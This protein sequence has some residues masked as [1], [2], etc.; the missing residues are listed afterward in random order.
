VVATD[1]SAEALAVAQHNARRHAL[2]NVTFRQG[3]WWEPLQ[4]QQFDLVVS[5]PPYIAAGDPHLTCGD[6]R[7]E[8]MTA[9]V[10]G[11]DGLDAI[12]AIVTPAASHLRPGGWLLLEHG[13]DQGRAVAALLA[14]AGFVHVA[15]VQD[16]EQRDRV[17]LGARP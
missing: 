3:S 16:W 5:N 17:T 11:D 10:A 9:L 12:R 2:V 6:L 14:E 15:T 4:D 1:I 13:W 8:P 7:F